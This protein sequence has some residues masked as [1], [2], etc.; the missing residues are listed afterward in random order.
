MKEIP[1]LFSTEMVQAILAGRKTMT[2]RIG[3]FTFP[4]NRE[5]IYDGTGIDGDLNHYFEEVINNEPSEKYI[6][7]GKCPYGQVGD[8]LWVRETFCPPNG[9]GTH[10][11]YM[12]KADWE[13]PKTNSRHD[14]KWKPAIHMPR[15]ACRIKL[16]ITNIR[17]E[18]LQD[19][20][21]QDAIKEGID[22]F[23]KDGVVFKYGLEGWHWSQHTGTPFMCYKS[24]HAFE[25]LWQSINGEE[26]WNAN[27]WVWVIE[28]ER[29]QE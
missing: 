6:S 5:F 1:I 11:D 9:Y 3:K 4:E 23:T 29:V 28:F 15:A 21:E 10:V 2:R 22:R 18:R 25:L 13:L 27:P 19:I 14:I 8:V 7:I 17:V 20:T 12:Y 26:S 16:R 24:K